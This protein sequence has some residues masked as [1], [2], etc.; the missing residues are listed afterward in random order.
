MRRGARKSLPLNG[1]DGL[2]REVVE[3]AVDARYLGQNAV[4]DAVEQVVR[5]LF[6][7]RRGRVH[8]VDGADDDRPSPRALAVADT[9]GA[10]IRH[11]REILPHLAL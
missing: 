7:R 11:G 2:R 4:G 8:G 3:N 9:G 5:D 10:I 1:G 6:D